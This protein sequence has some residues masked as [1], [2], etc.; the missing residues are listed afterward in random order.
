M[1]E[2]L[3]KDNQ[4]ARNKL[5]SAKTIFREEYYRLSDLEKLV[6]V[7]DASPDEENFLNLYYRT[8]IPK[9]WFTRQDIVIDFV[10]RQFG[11]NLARSEGKYVLDRTLEEQNVRRVDLGENVFEDFLA[12][13]KTFSE[14]RHIT[15]VFIP[16]DLYTHVYIDWPKESSELTIDYSTGGITICGLKPNIFWSNK[17]RPFSDFALIDKRFGKWTSKPSFTE[18]LTVKISESDK[19]DKL[20][21]LLLTKMKFEIVDAKKVLI[22]HRHLAENKGEV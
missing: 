9:E 10:F 16:V 11:E 6:E 1:A 4:Y 20:D 13:F 5:D 3:F 14:T 8:L 21:L 18:R 12:Y 17:Y 7:G 19:D 15:A 2:D 22:L